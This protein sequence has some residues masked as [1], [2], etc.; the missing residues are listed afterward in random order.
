MISHSSN[1]GC[2]SSVPSEF[3]AN[4]LLFWC[5]CFS[6][7]FFWFQPCIL[8]ISLP[9]THILFLFV[10][11]IPNF[12]LHSSGFSFLW[13]PGDLSCALWLPLSDV[14]HHR[15]QH[16]LN[17]PSNPKTPQ[18]TIL[19]ALLPQPVDANRCQPIFSVRLPHSATGCC[20]FLINAWFSFFM[21]SRCL[22]TRGVDAKL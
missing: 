20:Y 13:P 15:A 18:G 3:Q 9:L 8:P 1:H 14:A 12:F 17:K 5:L 7:F 19:V 21:Q 2:P 4:S 11:H 6:F 10:L 16:A 22:I